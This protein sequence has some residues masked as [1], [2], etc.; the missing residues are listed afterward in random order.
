M[1]HGNVA[2]RWLFAAAP[3]TRA[4]AAALGVA[5]I[6]TACADRERDPGHVDLYADLGDHHL[7]IATDAEAAQRYF[8]QGLRLQYGFNHAE[9]IR[10]YEE[11]LRY[12]PSCAMCWWGIA[13]A[14]GPN[15]NAGM[16][17]ESG[18]RAYAA[19]RKAGELSAEGPPKEVALIEAL[20]ARYGPDA[21][22]G[23]TALDSAYAGAMATVAEEYPGDADVLALY[24]ASLMNLSP[25][26]YWTPEL[27]PGAGT[28]E[29][30]AALAQ[31]LESDPDN[32]GA[33]HYFIH[34][35]EAAH[36]ERAVACADRLAALMPGAGH[37]V[38]MPGHIYIRV[39]RYADA[40]KANERAVHADEGYIA[41]QRPAGLYPTAYYP[42]NYH[43]MAFAAMMAGMSDRAISAARTVA[44]KVP[45]E[46]AAQIYWIQNVVVLPS[47]TLLTFGRWDDV[48]DEPMPPA[49]LATAT[50]MAHYARGT[51]F[52]ATGRG[53]EAETALAEIQRIAAQERALDAEGG[54]LDTGQGLNAVI[55]IAQH[56]LAGELALRSG[57]QEEAVA[58]FEAAAEIEDGL[59]YEEPPLWYYPI[60]HSLGRALLEADRPADAERAYRED[61][62]RFPDNGWSLYGLAASLRA[63]GKDA[64]AEELE[65]RFQAVWTEADVRITASRF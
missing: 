23:R 14:S 25:W 24:A 21:D 57:Q 27:E 19:I 34:A 22:A 9:A 11:A 55:A 2:R 12:D 50:A 8:D 5:T 20:A 62:E 4:L 61:L 13:L 54:A 60:R 40:V 58:H 35:V 31:A 1:K 42:H 48:L 33:C 41:D 46:V 6:S 49:N 53:A 45:P 29:I 3:G 51:A 18:R 26:D 28:D 56:A 32:P 30:L 63:Q 37:I 44:P 36:P 47:L 59:I 16:D 17:P 43:F 39:G 10:A 7:E 38:H 65:A 15:I 52:A 64:E